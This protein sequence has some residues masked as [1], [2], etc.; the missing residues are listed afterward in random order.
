MPITCFSSATEVP[1]A[2]RDRHHSSEEALPL[3]GGFH[4]NKPVFRRTSNH[5]NPACSAS[6][7]GGALSNGMTP[8]YCGSD[9]LGS[10]RSPSH[11][12]ELSALKAKPL[13]VSPE[14]HCPPLAGDPYWGN[15]LA[16]RGPLAR[17]EEE[18]LFTV[19][20]TRVAP[21][22]PSCSAVVA[23]Q[24][25][26]SPEGLPIGLQLVG[27]PWQ[28]MPL[29]RLAERVQEAIAAFSGGTGVSVIALGG[30]DSRGQ[31]AG[32]HR[33]RRDTARA[34]S[35]WKCSVRPVLDRMMHRSRWNAGR[36][37]RRVYQARRS[38]AGAPMRADR[39]ITNAARDRC[40]PPAT[41]HRP[42]Y[43]HVRSATIRTRTPIAS[44]ASARRACRPFPEA[45]ETKQRSESAA[46]APAAPAHR[47]TL[48]RHEFSLRTT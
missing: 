23:I 34:K 2:I 24:S 38:L 29:L 6:S 12:Y 35:L 40:C 41:V 27:R 11:I 39:C 7:S 10:I 36:M 22:N 30:F 44:S 9:M 31:L 43:V 14:R 42:Y 47:P 1:R 25:A 15:V 18:L 28:E 4:A 16:M 45:H 33:S 37:H 32:D 17:R 5:W 3:V 21:F 48:P 26:L 8:L 13:R 19:V 46:A 20:A